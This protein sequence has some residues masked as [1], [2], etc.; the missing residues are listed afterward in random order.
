MT[1]VTSDINCRLGGVAPNTPS[2]IVSCC[3]V[4]GHRPREPEL[5]A[6]WAWPEETAGPCN[7]AWSFVPQHLRCCLTHPAPWPPKSQLMY[8]PPS[9]EGSPLQSPHGCQRGTKASA[10][11]FSSWIIQ[12]VPPLSPKC[13]PCTRYRSDQLGRSRPPS[14]NS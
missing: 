3:K 2:P 8:T 6:A 11:C 10:H 1:A 7:T 13:P 14:L 5:C 12:A 4:Q 9:R